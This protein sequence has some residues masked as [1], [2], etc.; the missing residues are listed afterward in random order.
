MDA[1]SGPAAVFAELCARV[2]DSAERARLVG[3]S[4]ELD[5]AWARGAALPLLRAHRKA[6]ERALRLAGEAAAGANE[7]KLSA[8][9]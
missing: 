1:A 3:V 2:P 6:V 4:L 9:S 5:A 7:G 8:P